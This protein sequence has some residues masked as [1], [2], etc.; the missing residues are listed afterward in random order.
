MSRW[1]GKGNRGLVLGLWASCQSVG[2]I[3]GALIVSKVLVWGY[4]V[5]L[6]LIPLSPSL[7]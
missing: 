6:I 5:R 1:F 7:S 2:N 3:V 4:E